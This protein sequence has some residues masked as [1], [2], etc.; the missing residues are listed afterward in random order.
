MKVEGECGTTV[1]IYQSLRAYVRY[2]SSDQSHYTKN[3]TLPSLF[4]TFTRFV[5]KRRTATGR[6]FRP[7]IIGQII[8]KAYLS[9]DGRL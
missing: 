6:H 2:N 7:F 5:L 8:I 9:G 1:R 4:G 3:P